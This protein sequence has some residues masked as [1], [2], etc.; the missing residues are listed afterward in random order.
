M[1]QEI[2]P[3]ELKSLSDDGQ[4]LVLDVRE[5]GEHTGEHIPGDINVPLQSVSG[6]VAKL[7]GG[8]TVV[9]YCSSGRRGREAAV[10]LAS[11]S[12]GVEIRNLKGGIKAWKQ[13]GMPLAREAGPKLPLQQQVQVVVGIGVLTGLFLGSVAS[14]VFYWLAAFFGAGLIFAGLTG[15]CGMALLLAHMPWNKS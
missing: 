1:P 10:T 4:A 12:A 5:P 13:A 6:E 7:A 11:Q 9:A 3:Q 2:S 8:K 14:P 15:F